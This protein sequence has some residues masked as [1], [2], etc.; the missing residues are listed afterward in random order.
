MTQDLSNLHAPMTLTLASGQECTYFTKQ[1]SP[2][3]TYLTLSSD[4]KMLTLQSLDPSN[5]GTHVFTL[6]FVPTSW[7]TGASPVILTFQVVLKACDLSS[8]KFSEKPI[9][10]SFYTI[11]DEP[12]FLDPDGLPTCENAPVTYSASLADD[13]LPS[14]I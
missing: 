8:F 6:T 5:T 1:L 12:L 2:T 4:Q 13:V 9:P 3:A 14:F 11:G 7:N 10:N